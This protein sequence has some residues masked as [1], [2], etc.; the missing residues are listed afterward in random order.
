MSDRYSAEQVWQN[1][2]PGNKQ[3]TV[4]RQTVLVPFN[5]AWPQ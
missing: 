3:T 4:S 1:M 5:E 2:A